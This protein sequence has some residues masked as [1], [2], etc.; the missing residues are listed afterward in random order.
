M[1][2][3]GN[4]IRYDFYIPSINAIFEIDGEQHFEED[5]KWYDEQHSKDTEKTRLANENGIYVVRFVQEEIWDDSIDWK[6]MMMEMLENGISENKYISLEESKYEMH[7]EML[8]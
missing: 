6:E 2:N 4:K 5:H 3:N 8:N 1:N 7:K